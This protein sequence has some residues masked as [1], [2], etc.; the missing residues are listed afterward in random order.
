MTINGIK[1][2]LRCCGLLEEFKQNKFNRSSILTAIGIIEDYSKSKRKEYTIEQ[3]QKRQKAKKDPYPFLIKH[4]GMLFTWGRFRSKV[5]CIL[6]DGLE[7]NYTQH[8]IMSLYM[9][10]IP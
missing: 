7:D 4:F 3:N 8:L 5:N 1:F 2:Y 9:D 6:Q 10:Y